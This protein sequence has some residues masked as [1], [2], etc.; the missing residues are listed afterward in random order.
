MTRF[1]TTA[2]AILLSGAAGSAEVFH[3]PEPESIDRNQVHEYIVI[4]DE[5]ALAMYRGSISGLPA[6]ER[7]KGRA[8]RLK[9]KGSKAT[10]YVSHLEQRQATVQSAIEQQLDRTVEPVHRMQ[11]ALNAIVVRV[12][13]NEAEQL[14]ELTGIKRVE[15]SVPRPLLTDRGPEFIG[16]DAVW[17]GLFGDGSESSAGEGVVVGVIDSGANFDHPSYAATGDDGFTVTNPLGSGNFL[18]ECGQVVTC[19]DKIIG[20]YDFVSDNTP[21]GGDNGVGGGEDENNHGSHTSSTAGGNIT[22]INFNG[23]SV[24]ISGV[25]PHANLVIF[26]ACYTRTSDGLGLCPTASTSM[27]VNQAVADGVVDVI[28]YSIGGGAVPWSDTVS[29]AFLAATN[30]GIVVSASAGNSGPGPGTL[31]HLEPWTI[32][33]GA[34]THDRAFT[35]A[36]VDITEAGAPAEVMDIGAVIGTGPAITGD[37]TA[38]FDFFS[39]NI[40]GCNDGGGFPAGQFT[41]EIALISRGSCTFEEKVQNANSAGAV[42]VVIYNNRAGAPIVMGGLETTTIP[43]VMTGQNSGMAVQSFIQSNPTP[44]GQFAQVQSARTIDPGFGDLMAD[45]SSRGPSTID[46]LKPDVTAPGVAILAAY[47]DND[48]ATG[49]PPENGFL[50]GTSMSSPHNA[51]AV[52]VL[53]SLH[54]DWTGM[55]IKSA[56]VTT[57]ETD[58]LEQ[59]QNDAGETIMV[60]TDAFDVG[61][62][63]IVVDQAAQAGLVLH[64]TAANFAAADPGAGGDPASLNLPSMQQDDCESGCSWQRTVRNSKDETTT[65]Q[66]SGQGD[67]FTVDVIPDQFSLLPGD[68]VFRDNNEQTVDATSSFQE[69]EV[70]VDAAPGTDFLFGAVVFSENGGLAPDARLPIA[71]N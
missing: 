3:G 47:S 70:T 66:G 42:G 32:T 40:E 29:Q 31:G 28:N 7:K 26:D 59:G 60:P 43:S 64:E 55:E 68:V 15:R 12:D 39:D 45:F 46:V 27:S 22:N 48:G 61:G 4:L 67:G 11:H 71:V 56:L 8:G 49:T 21:A 16:A 20:A 69:I 13:A 54:L 50:Q 5:P 58:L 51:G 18:G 52:A 25:A 9:V 1:L 38:P 34:S 19:T 23:L 14:A 10:A 41:A 2:L 36:E 63:R 35:D 57:G 53:R 44:A 17:D 30:A 6:P 65:W 24:D 33:V 62:G 37:I